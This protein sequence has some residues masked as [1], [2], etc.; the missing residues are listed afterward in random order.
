VIFKRPEVENS[1][2]FSLDGPL[3]FVLWKKSAETHAALLFRLRRVMKQ[4]VEAET[5]ECMLFYTHLY[6]IN[7]QFRWIELEF[8]NI[9]FFKL[10]V[11]IIHQCV[12]RQLN[13]RFYF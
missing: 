1:S 11:L 12:W 10:S 9:Y 6:N 3:V 7:A 13:A 4:D 5:I 8:L 2:M